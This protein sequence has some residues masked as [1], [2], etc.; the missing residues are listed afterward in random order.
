MHVDESDETAGKASCSIEDSLKSGSNVTVG[1]NSPPEKQRLLSVL[2]EAGT[3][4]DESDQPWQ[5]TASATEERF[6]A[7]ENVTAKSNFDCQKQDPQSVASSLGQMSFP[8]E[9]PKL[10]NNR[11][12][13]LPRMRECKLTQV[14]KMHEKQNRRDAKAD[15]RF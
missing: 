8:K 4:I 11:R 9:P 15:S 12:P 10:E 7:D 13:A 3:Q 14:T 5:K 2:A 1:R 6:E